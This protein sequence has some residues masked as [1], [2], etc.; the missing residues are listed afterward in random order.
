MKYLKDR[1]GEEIRAFTPIIDKQIFQVLVL[2]GV[3]EG[4]IWVESETLTQLMLA[5]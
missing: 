3:E 2:H 5:I 4:G 1:I